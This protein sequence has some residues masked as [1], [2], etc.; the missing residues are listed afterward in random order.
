MAGAVSD[1]GD[2]QRLRSESTRTW[3]SLTTNETPVSDLSTAAKV[4]G[5]IMHIGVSGFANYEIICERDSDFAIMLDISY[6][7]FTCMELTKEAIIESDTREDFIVNF[8]SKIS[9]C[10]QV[11]PDHLSP[12]DLTLAIKT[13]QE[14]GFLSDESKYQK[15][16]I[17]IWTR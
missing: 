14:R 9:L 5:L 16:K 2:L 11:Y 7:V 12:N 8:T 3:I 6:V 1:L 15:I 17:I 13:A 4:A 10:S